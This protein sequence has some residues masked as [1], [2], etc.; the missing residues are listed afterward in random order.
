MSDQLRQIRQRKA[1]ADAMASENAEERKAKANKPAKAS[2]WFHHAEE[3]IAQGVKQFIVYA[4]VSFGKKFCHKVKH[5]QDSLHEILE[6]LGA[7]SAGT[8]GEINS[9]QLKHIYDRVQFFKAVEKARRLG[10]PVLVLCSSRL[11]RSNAYNTIWNKDEKP[12]KQDFKAFLGLFPGVQFAT[13]LH[14][15]T[16]NVAEESYLRKLAQQ[17]TGRT[18]GR[19]NKKSKLYQ[20]TRREKL[21]PKVHELRQQGYGLGKIAKTLN[22]KKPTV[23]KWVAL[24]K[25]THPEF[26]SVAGWGFSR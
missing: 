25:R 4:R 6:Q 14:P 23:Q 20:T 7:N 12:T 21:L 24:L 15:D 16:D 19:P 26:R 17:T 3:L 1:E 13:V 10:L 8:F 18:G 11:L 9:G 2:R 5:Q 22:L